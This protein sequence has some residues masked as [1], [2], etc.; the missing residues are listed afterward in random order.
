LG[1]IG[2]DTILISRSREVISLFFLFIV[3]GIFSQTD[4]V[5]VW[6]ARVEKDPSDIYA[7][8]FL[9]EELSTNDPKQC[10]PYSDKL[11][12][13]AKKVKNGSALINGYVTKSIAMRELAKYNEALEL[14]LEAIA[15]AERIK[16][17]ANIAHTY[18]T[19][20]V[21][22]HVTLNYPL[23]EKYYKKAYDIFVLMKSKQNEFIVT[24]NLSDVYE[25]TGRKKLAEE[26]L[27]RSIKA[28]KE[29]GDKGYI[30]VGYYSLAS[31]LVSEKI[32]E[33]GMHV[34]DSAIYYLKRV[35]DNYYYYQTLV[36]K[37][38]ALHGLGKYE[39]SN[40]ILFEILTNEVKLE[41]LDLVHE[42]YYVLSKNYE[43]LNKPVEALKYARLEKEVSDSIFKTESL[44][45]LKEA[46]T[47]FDSEKQEKE[48]ELL[49][50]E[51]EISETELSRQKTIR[52]SF[53]IG[54]I[55]VL[56]FSVLIF[57]SLQINRRDKKMISVQKEKL[58]LKNKEIMDSIRYAKRIQ[59]A[60]LPNDRY[61]DKILKKRGS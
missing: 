27:E 22:Y 51:K 55:V 11:I 13:Q 37:S 12:E 42:T 20:A 17:T 43:K 38:E 35:N 18:N 1:R 36:V 3:S 6:K 21:F 44:A 10:I 26:A 58:E 45:A 24:S 23:A 46:Q 47:K 32:F 2:S 48:I 52:N 61:I 50:K 28:R 49:N 25:K 19:L 7:L 9:T 15:V 8:D 53:I 59:S 56:A 34:C 4:S 33:K 31:F 5:S 57:R 14:N 39:A 30:A 60:L 16:D 41:N 29:F 40:Q 54:S